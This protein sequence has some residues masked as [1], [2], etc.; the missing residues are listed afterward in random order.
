M[1]ARSSAPFVVFAHGQELEAPIR[2]ALIKPLL[3]A[4]LILT[5]SKMSAGRLAHLNEK[6]HRLPQVRVTSP[7][8]S[9]DRIAQWSSLKTP[10]Q[11]DSSVVLAVGRI[12]ET[13]P[14]KGFDTLIRALP[15]VRQQVPDARLV[16]VGEGSGRGAL[17]HLATECGVTQYV[18]FTGYVSVLELGYLYRTASVFAMPSRQEGFGIVYAEAMWH[19]LPCIGSTADAAGEV[20]RD[21]ETGLLTEYGNVD[22]TAAALIRILTDRSWAKALGGAGRRRCLALYSPQ[23]YAKELRSA[24]ETVTSHRTAR[25]PR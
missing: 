7:C 10:G 14:G 4:S 15:F 23:A 20:I 1:P 21:G 24:M 6:G 3:R 17:E 11:F 13:E 12:S 8:V 18:K 19:G 25:N 9:R 22:D 5:V 16:V 2:R